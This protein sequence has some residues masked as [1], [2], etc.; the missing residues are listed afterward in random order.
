MTR[1]GQPF[2]VVDIGSNTVKLYV[3][4]C[5]SLGE[6]ES[7]F[8]HAD[9]VRVGQGV[10]A[11]GR[12]SDDRAERLVETLQYMEQTAN[13]HGATRLFAIATEAF[14]QAANAQDV[15]RDIHDRTGWRVDII[16]G[17]DETRL[18]FEAAQSF[19]IEGSATVIADIG[20]A[21]T[22]L[23][24]VSDQGTLVAAG[25]VTLGSGSLFDEHVGAS[26]PPLGTLATARRHSV[27]RLRHSCLLPDSTDRLLLPGG[28]GHFLQELLT[29]IHSTAVLDQHGLSVLSNWLSTMQASKTAELLGI[30]VQRA[31]VLPAGLA[32]VEALVAE[33]QPGQARAIPSGIGLGLARRICRNNGGEPGCSLDMR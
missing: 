4:V 13:G 25:S 9:T 6:P 12:I 18:T 5:D 24:V 21:S 27:E 32:I 15:Q 20:G 16:S 17:D 23:V 29:I 31:R 26:P 1:S 7:V 11:S 28:T 8:H 10:T 19:I 22:E 30:Q 2:A 33:L 3:F 14:R